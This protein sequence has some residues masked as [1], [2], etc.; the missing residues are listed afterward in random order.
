VVTFFQI[1]RPAH[2]IRRAPLLLNLCLHYSENKVSI[3]TLDD[4]KE[5][6]RCVNA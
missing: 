6:E 5:Y 4:M 2:G 1:S 3:N